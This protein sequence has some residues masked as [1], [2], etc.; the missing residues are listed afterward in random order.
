VESALS[1]SVQ[2]TAR[3]F[4]KLSAQLIKSAPHVLETATAL[5]LG[6]ALPVKMGPVSSASQAITVLMKR[7]SATKVVAKPVILNWIAPD[8]EATLTAKRAIAENARKIM[9][10]KTSL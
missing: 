8:L 2:R 4:P 9:I 1:A 3:V 7:L 10:V 5:V 6:V